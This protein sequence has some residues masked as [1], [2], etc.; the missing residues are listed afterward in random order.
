[1][2][3]HGLFIGG[4]WRKAHDYAP[5]RNPSDLAD[6]IGEYGR[7]TAQDVDDAVDA[8]AAALVGW[9][10]STPQQRFD[11]LD[12]AASE[13]LAR[14]E[15]LGELLSR[16]EGK[17]RAE[18]IGEATRAGQVFKFFAGE[19]LRLTGERVPSVRPGVHV[20]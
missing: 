16:E 2:S 9:S 19:A 4:E 18:G 3:K 10:Q 7:G 6:V 13:I 11:V 5:N 14:R 12:A 15:E 17:T 8:A 20:R 1:M